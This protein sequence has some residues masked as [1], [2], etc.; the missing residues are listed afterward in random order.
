MELIPDTPETRRRFNDLARH[1]FI[2]KM[3]AEILA[4]MQVCELEGWGKMEF[5][6]MLYDVLKH[7]KRGENG[8]E[9]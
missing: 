4:D 2:V 9:G 5:I 8:E 6:N 7:F 3:Y 1:N